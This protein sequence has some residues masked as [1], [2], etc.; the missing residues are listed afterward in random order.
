MQGR[1]LAL[2]CALAC[3]FAASAARAAS[4]WWVLAARLDSGDQVL[5]EF[6]ITDVGPGD[7]NAAA[8]GTWLARDGTRTSFSRAKL[9]G[10]W[11]ESRDG[12]RVDLEKF[13][14][15]RSKPQAELRV[16]KGSLRIALDFP[17]ASAPLASHAFAGGKWTQELWSAG[18]PLKATLWRKGM[19]AAV[20]GV[21]RVA[22]SRRR[23]EGP[24][25]KLAQRRA[26]WFALGA[27]PVYAV[28]IAHT[29][30]AERW[31]VA[32]DAAGRPVAQE[33]GAASVGGVGLVPARVALAGPAVAGTLGAGKQLAAYDPLADVP[34]LIRLALGLR[35]QSVWMASPFAFEVREAAHLGHREG[36]AVASYTFYR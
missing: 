31:V 34:S 16:E 22:L 7:R 8:I 12:R 35:L 32:C 24:E 19:P 20:R 30:N 25:A 17:L 29:K 15:D 9:E 4:E 21:G 23:I 13:V 1:V 5:V 3:A 33:T 28:E 14:F 11:S 26:E 2:A 6:T 10:D 27:A 18:A 36:I